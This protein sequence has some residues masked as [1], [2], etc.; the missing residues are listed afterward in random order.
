MATQKIED[1]LTKELFI[2]KNIVTYR[3]LSRE[4]GI[5]VNVA[6]NELAAFHSRNAKSLEQPC[7]ATYL[8]SGEV[9][10]APAKNDRDEDADMDYGF[11]PTPV[12]DYGFAGTG[13]GTGTGVE[14]DGDVVVQVKITVVSETALEDAKAKYV[15]VTSV[16]VYSLSPSPIRDADLL[17]APTRRIR[18]VDDQKGVEMAKV[19][20]RIVGEGIKMKEGGAKGK[21]RTAA[22]A[23]TT[24]QHA[25]PRLR[26]GPSA[27]GSFTATT[28][29]EE[30]GKGSTKEEPERPKQ[31]GKLNFFA[32]KAK[33]PP[34]DKEKEGSSKNVAEGKGKMFFGG[35]TKSAASLTKEPAPVV[36][37]PLPKEDKVKEAAPAQ[38]G[39]KRKSMAAILSDCEDEETKSNSVAPS[40]PPSRR[41]SKPP[42]TRSSPQPMKA[43]SKLRLHKGAILSD[44]D[45]DDEQPK[46]RSVKKPRRKAN[47]DSDDEIE[48][49]SEAA[50]EAAKALKS[51]ME[52]DDDQ[53]EKVSRKARVEALR[54]EEEEET[55]SEREP[56]APAI[57]NRDGDVDMSDAEVKLK[58]KPR[59]R[60]E[61]KTVPVGQ[62]GLKKRRVMKSRMR[63]DEKGYMVT[64]D[65]SSY[66][67]V[68]EEEE[69][70]KKSAPAKKGN[71]GKRGAA[72]KK[73]KDEPKETSVPTDSAA[74]T[75]APNGDAKSK[76][77]TKAASTSTKASTSRSGSGPKGA[78]KQKTLNTFFG[79]PKAKK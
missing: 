16:H 45:E 17:C 6:K 33:A 8:V 26:A 41:S 63:T 23:A 54:Q 74:G 39:M 71:G 60:K 43:R 12:Q 27:S 46:K 51:M 56:P 11:T 20:G 14:M 24:A 57:I 79:L 13:T 53:V 69:E 59:K 22:A 73:D 66:E 29:P 78:Q 3:S 2:S 42:S 28:K 55:E 21:G 1:Y 19:A 9:Q 61:K 38:R 5:N 40:G 64:E 58:P 62:N 34:K 47:V 65:Y 10:T 25:V 76:T 50:K 7:S 48:H 70:P 32:P 30:K 18:E 75:A 15:R 37:P 77:T 52:I 44:D 67:S 4:L 31:T 72:S 35:T 49:D 68:D 36:P